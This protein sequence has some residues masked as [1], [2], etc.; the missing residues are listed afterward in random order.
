MPQTGEFV[1]KPAGVVGVGEPVDPLRGSRE[2][3][4][5]V[6]LAGAD[7]RPLWRGGRADA[8]QLKNT[9]SGH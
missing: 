4:L 3:N 9:L 1:L 6:G 7:N 2:L 8:R 5:M